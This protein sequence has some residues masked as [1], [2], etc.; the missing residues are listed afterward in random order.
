METCT[1]LVKTDKMNSQS[2]GLTLFRNV[3][4]RQTFSGFTPKACEHFTLSAV[5]H[6]KINV[7][8]WQHH[9]RIAWWIFCQLP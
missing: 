6:L 1:I 4:A 2:E 3:V 5:F 8:K 9:G 7:V